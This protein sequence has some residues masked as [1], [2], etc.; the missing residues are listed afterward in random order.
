MNNEICGTNTR[1]Y[2]P[3]SVRKESTL[4]IFIHSARELISIKVLKSW[5][6]LLCV[7]NDSKQIQ[8][9]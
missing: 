9:K 4:K 5:L 2:T 7:R 8:Y 1:K 3:L 6:H